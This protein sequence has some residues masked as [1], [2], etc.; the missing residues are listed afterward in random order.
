MRKEIKNQRTSAAKKKKSFYR[1]VDLYARLRAPGGCPWDRAQSHATLK[2]YLI[3]EAY[4]VVEAIEEGNY[5]KMMEELG[6]LLGQVIFHSQ[7]AKERGRFDIDRA[8]EHHQ[9]KMERRH[10]HIFGQAK[11]DSVRQVLEN[12]E[13]I[14]RRE[15]DRRRRPALHG[16]PKSLPALLR[17]RRVQEKADRLGY[18]WEEED[19]AFALAE[20]L[21]SDLSS[22]RIR[23]RRKIF[24]LTLGRLLFILVNMARLLDVDPEDAL[25]RATAAFIKDFHRWEKKNQ[26]KS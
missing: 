2:P 13:Q 24:P 20:K 11:V 14:K 12:W 3:E 22:A 19:G 15:K 10:P 17:A 23:R 26:P 25:R 7:L 5:D 6:D 18:R 9:Q 1:L 21:L 16:V 8:I 4:E